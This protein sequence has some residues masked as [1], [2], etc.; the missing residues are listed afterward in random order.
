MHVNAPHTNSSKE[1][2]APKIAPSSFTSVVV[3]AE[4]T[5]FVKEGSCESSKA[6]YSA[7][8]KKRKAL[9]QANSSTTARVVEENNQISHK[10]DNLLFSK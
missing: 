1:H 6:N 5:A 2:S 3:V 9:H 8:T 10:W 4:S 7:M